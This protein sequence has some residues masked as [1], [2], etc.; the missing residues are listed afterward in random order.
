[1][2]NKWLCYANTFFFFFFFFLKDNPFKAA[3]LDTSRQREL[4]FE[5]TFPSLPISRSRNIRDPCITLADHDSSDAHVRFRVPLSRVGRQ[6][7]P[8]ARQDNT[9]CRNGRDGR[10]LFRDYGER[11]KP[12]ELIIG[13]AITPQANENW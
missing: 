12:V 1:M 6:I 13:P 4:Y 10:V 7:F 5:R 2:L 11:A 3:L 9:S 8:N